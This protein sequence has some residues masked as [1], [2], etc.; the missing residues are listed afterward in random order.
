MSQA[1]QRY[2][3]CKPHYVHS[4]APQLL[5][6]HASSRGDAAKEVTVSKAPDESKPALYFY[7][8]GLQPDPN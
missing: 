8:A 3:G 2:G 7:S 5:P 6:K 4:L 1:L